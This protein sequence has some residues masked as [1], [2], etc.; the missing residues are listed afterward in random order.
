MSR[1][2]RTVRHSRWWTPP[3]PVRSMA[4]GAPLVRQAL[5]E[6][7]AARTHRGSTVSCDL[8]GGLDSTSVCFLAAASPARVIASTWPGRDPADS[9]L[10]WARR[11]ARHLPHVEHVVWD[12]DESP[13][14]YTDLLD[15]D[16]PMDEPTIGVMDRARVRCTTSRSSPAAAVRRT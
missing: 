4:G 1:D 8:S 15:I 10:A 12:A 9:D 7:V 16:E 13:L 6:A 5:T 11:A 2:G 14:V 3:E